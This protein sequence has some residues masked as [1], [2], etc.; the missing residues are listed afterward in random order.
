MSMRRIYHHQF[1]N[2]GLELT[3]ETLGFLPAHAMNRISL[4]LDSWVSDDFTFNNVSDFPRNPKQAADVQE[5]AVMAFFRENPSQKVY[6]DDFV[7]AEGQAWFQYAR[8]IW[9]EEYCIKCHGKQSDAPPAIRN[10]YDTAF[11]Y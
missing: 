11:N 10:L 1:I 9:L 5:L 4:D 7:D 3:P 8:P 2:S 6:F